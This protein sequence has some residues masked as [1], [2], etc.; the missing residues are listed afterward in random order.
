MRH[1]FIMLFDIRFK[2]EIYKSIN[3]YLFDVLLCNNMSSVSI[4]YTALQYK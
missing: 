2:R 3:Y 4:L 1:T